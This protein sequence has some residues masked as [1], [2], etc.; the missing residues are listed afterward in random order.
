M[1]GE[2][3]V[4][5]RRAL[6]E[7]AE[8]DV[9][10]WGSPASLM[11]A[12]DGRAK[13][14]AE[15]IPRGARVLDLGCGA[16]ALEGFLPSDCAYQPCDLAARDERTIVCD[17]NAG[18]FPD[19]ECDVAVALGVLEYLKDVP[20]FLRKLRALNRPVVASYSL[21]GEGPSDRRALG[22]MNDFTRA[23]L[24][25]LLRAA[26]FNRAFA[27]GI[28]NGQVLMRLDPTAPPQVAEK[29]VWVLSHSNVS[30]FGDRL[31]VHLLSQV[32][33]AHAVVRHIQHKPFDAPPEG[34]PDL[35]ILGLG[36]SLYT[37][38]LTDDLAALIARAPRSV[39]IFGT[40]YRE[41]MDRPRL[42]AVID[43]LDTW[44]ARYEEDALIYGQGRE[45]VRHL[46]DWLIDAFLMSRP[47][48]DELLVVDAG[49]D[50]ETPLDRT[51]EKIQRHRSVMSARLH[52]LLCALTSAETV[53]YEEQWAKD[54]WAG[55]HCSGKFRSMLLDVFG[56]A[57]SSENMWRVD[58]S[59]VIGYK[60]KVA[61]NISGL[62]A[63][64]TRLLA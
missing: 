53:G 58:R 21:A 6:A 11:P 27:R 55:G 5:R 49:F 36:N 30:N 28:E 34:A 23:E 46:G 33:P 9:Q 20:A 50:M 45:N 43:R 52:P 37:P 26:G 59:A 18:E 29:T 54:A 32:L 14:A 51:I 1:T 62:R 31:G 38:L 13:I 17:F 22:W 35:L 44:F 10:R 61:A 56:M 48:D 64:L 19:A 24:G 40:Q 57:W 25:G 60:A 42:A 8:T 15:F 2:T 7:R 12:W 63:E 3:D 41:V 47:T 39:G 16:M 4:D